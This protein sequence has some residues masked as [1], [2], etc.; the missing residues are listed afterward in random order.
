VVD[1]NVGR[2]LEKLQ[3]LGLEFPGGV[4]TTDLLPTMLEAARLPL[5][6]TAGAQPDSGYQARRPYAKLETDPPSLSFVARTS[7]AGTLQPG[8]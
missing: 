6:E 5:P 3:F 1:W 2:L 7:A 8:G 4:S